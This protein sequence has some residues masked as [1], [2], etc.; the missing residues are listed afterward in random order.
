MLQS[1]RLKI[2]NIEFTDLDN[3]HE[4]HSLPETDRF[5]TLGIPETLHVTS[6]LL[7]EWL[8]LGSQNPRTSYVFCIERKVDSQFIGLIALNLG[9]VNYNSGEI[10]YKTHI[11]FWDK[12]YT[13]EALTSLLEFSFNELKLHRIEAGC[14]VDNAASVRVLEKVGMKLSLIHI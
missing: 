8:F 11:A 3:I 6:V 2:R 1:N 14:A 5:N 10:W 4:L 7:E 12:G 9:K 13:T